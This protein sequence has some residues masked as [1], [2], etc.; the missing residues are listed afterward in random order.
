MHLVYIYKEFNYTMEGYI[1]GAAYYNYFLSYAAIENDIKK[2]NI[3]K[4]RF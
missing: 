4:E 3:F 2:R 1:T